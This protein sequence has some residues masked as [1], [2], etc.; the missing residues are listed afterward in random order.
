MLNNVFF[1]LCLAGL[2]WVWVF[3]PVCDTMLMLFLFSCIFQY[4]LREYNVS[5]FF[6]C[7]VLGRFIVML[8]SVGMSLLCRVLWTVVSC[9]FCMQSVSYQRKQAANSSQNF[10]I[11]FIFESKIRLMSSS[12]FGYSFCFILYLTTLSQLHV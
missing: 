5:V 11:W 2:C 1:V 4:N 10:L 9:V 6:C 12:C 8:V 3:F 7:I